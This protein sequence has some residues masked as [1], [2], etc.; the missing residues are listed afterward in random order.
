M[1]RKP[2]QRQS[3]TCTLVVKTWLARQVSQCLVPLINQMSYLPFKRR[4]QVLHYETLMADLSQFID[5][6]LE[7]VI[8]DR[9]AVEKRFNNQT[10]NHMVAVH[11][12]SPKRYSIRLSH[13]LAQG[14]FA[15][16]HELVRADEQW[17]VLAWNAEAGKPIGPDFLSQGELAVYEKWQQAQL[18]WTQEFARTIR[19]H[20]K[21]LRQAG[22]PTT[23][24]P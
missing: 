5:A 21:Q 6:A 4:R 10:V 2:R 23:K 14:L 1:S 7:T 9:T 15:L 3:I 22:Q 19:N 16:L 8:A 11:F 12:G 13:P 17:A 24:A 20:L 18:A